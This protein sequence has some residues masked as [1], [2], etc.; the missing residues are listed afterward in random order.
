[1]SWPFPIPDWL[2]WWVL[3]IVLVLALLYFLLFLVMPFSVF[4]VKGRLDLIEQR[5]AEIQ[6]ELRMQTS[7]PLE[8]RAEAEPED[9]A[10]PRRQP[11][12]G[13]PPRVEP[14]VGWPRG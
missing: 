2:P 6:V 8:P 5:L 1:M 4:G 9:R 11:P 7:R 10:P 14:R 13:P 12:P 3:L